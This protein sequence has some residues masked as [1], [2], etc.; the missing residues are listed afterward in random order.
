MSILHGLVPAVSRREI[1]YNNEAQ[2]MKQHTA[3]EQTTL[4]EAKQDYQINIVFA[5]QFSLRLLDLLIKNPETKKVSFALFEKI[6]QQLRLTCN[7][8]ISAMD[9]STTDIQSSRLS[10]TTQPFYPAQTTATTQ[11]NASDI[12]VEL[13][14]IDPAISDQ[15][16][17][18]V[19]PETFL[20]IDP[21]TSTPPDTYKQEI[22][23]QDLPVQP[24]A[25]QSQPNASVVSN[26]LVAIEPALS[27]QYRTIKE[28]ST[29]AISMENLLALWQTALKIEGEERI[30]TGC[31]GLFHK[32]EKETLPQKVVGDAASYIVQTAACLSYPA[33][34]QKLDFSPY[35]ILEQKINYSCSLWLQNMD[36]TLAQ[37]FSSSF[38]TNLYSLM[39][40]ENNPASFSDKLSTSFEFALKSVQ[41]PGQAN[42]DLQQLNAIKHAMLFGLKQS[43]LSSRLFGNFDLEPI[44][45][46]LMKFLDI[47]SAHAGESIHPDLS[48]LACSSFN[49]DID[50]DEQW[51][52]ARAKFNILTQIGSHIMQLN[53]SAEKEKL[54]QYFDIVKF[55]F[56]NTPNDFDSLK[57]VFEKTHNWLETF[58]KRENLKL[59]EEENPIYKTFFEQF[60]NWYDKEINT[61]IDSGKIKIENPELESETSASLSSN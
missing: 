47:N 28:T 58:L 9:Q 32:T 29:S 30:K 21:N 48:Q 5:E 22:T 60:K 17:T 61:L 50:H 13:S 51:A 3:I 53:P 34:W 15:Y 35:M 16:R 41:T 39:V 31:C 11:P 4:M 2:Y 33:S 56:T 10:E 52:V 20:S 45:Q 1:N 26:E 14:T 49:K 44:K 40:D 43:L 19:L 6:R 25:T 38:T 7:L 46:A 18:L 42:D 55:I 59:L 37:K 57:L 54:K 27:S 24:T 8:P 36:Q 12:S 23:D